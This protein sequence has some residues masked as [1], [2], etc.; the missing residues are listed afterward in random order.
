MS[1]YSD[2]CWKD[3][4][5]FTDDD[6]SGEEIPNISVPCFILLDSSV[7]FLVREKFHVSESEDF[8]HREDKIHTHGNGTNNL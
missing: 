4:K 8:I 2:N 3:D 7:I 5:L 6:D 1:D